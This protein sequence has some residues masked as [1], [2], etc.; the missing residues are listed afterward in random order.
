M[1]VT[2]RGD[3]GADVVLEGDTPDDASAAQAAGIVAGV[4]RRHND[5]LTSLLTHGLLDRA[6]VTTDG[7][8]VR[9][10]LTATRDHLETLSVLVSGFL[11]VEPPPA[12]AGSAPPP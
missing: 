3:D 10:T 12:A 11:G 6:Q 7:N 1:R 5:T 4:V 9:V 2:L 8:R